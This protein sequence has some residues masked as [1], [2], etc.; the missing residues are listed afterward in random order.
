MDV[1][2]LSQKN[3]QELSKLDKLS[4]DQISKLCRTFLQSVLTG[5][6]GKAV[7]KWFSFHRVYLSNPLVLLH[8]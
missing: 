2:I 1:L 6:T 4:A 3:L 8:R 7:G 5:S